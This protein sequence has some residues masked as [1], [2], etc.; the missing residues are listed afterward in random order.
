MKTA[1]CM[2]N[3]TH[4]GVI[5]FSDELLA[6]IEELKKIVQESSKGL[7]A[8]VPWGE[9]VSME[10]H[11]GGMTWSEDANGVGRLKA[12]A[13]GP[14]LAYA[15][16]NYSDMRCVD[17]SVMIHVGS[18]DACV[19]SYHEE[20]A[21]NPLGWRRL[22]AYGRSDDNTIGRIPE[23]HFSEDFLR[24]WCEHLGKHHLR[25]HREVVHVV[26]DM[27][28]EHKVLLEKATAAYLE[29]NKES[30]MECK[31]M[32]QTILRES[33]DSHIRRV[34]ASLPTG[35]KFKLGLDFHGVLDDDREYFS[36]LSRRVLNEGGEV[37]VIT[38][39]QDTPE[40]RDK[41]A[42]LGVVFSHFFSISTYHTDIGT[43]VWEDDRGPWMDADVWDKSK[44]EYCLRHGINIHIDDSPVY[45][46]HF[47]PST[48]YVKY[49]E[50]TTDVHNS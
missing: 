38:G 32:E 37:H 16:H 43:T 3:L 21:D 46:K 31:E 9:I 47:C 26:E 11:Y 19:E 44:A 2:L 10:I 22:G 29:E 1:Y 40:L 8:D 30:L 14:V 41:I 23:V 5:K 50:M 20:G 33:C 49:P 35:E 12:S 13:N 17:E 28:A 45:G 34:I 36:N 24:A 48:V 15:H 42:R 4:C 18:D 27:P 6:R 25:T 39:S 7:R